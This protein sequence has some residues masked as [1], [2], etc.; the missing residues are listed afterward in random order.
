MISKELRDIVK[1]RKGKIVIFI[2]FFIPMIELVL[3]IL[4]VY[5]DYWLH[6]EA[7]GGTLDKH[8]IYHPSKAAFLSGTSL[9]H[10][11]QMLLVWLLPLF[12]LLL[13]DDSYIR[14]CRIGYNNI[15][16]VRTSKKSVFFSKIITGFIAGFTIIFFSMALNYLLSNLCFMGGT[17]F[18]GLETAVNPSDGILYISLQHPVITYLIYIFAFSFIAGVYSVFCVSLS[19]VI[20]SYK[21]LY[22]ACVVI[23]FLQILSPFSI[24]YAI[25]PFIEYGLDKIIPAILIL[26]ALV[27]LSVI[28]GLYAKVKYERI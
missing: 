11:P 24:T 14:E 15:I 3:N 21:M 27:L 19:F 22:G 7:Y 12:L 16:S 1:S 9:G 18:R 10:M 2:I 17:S 20:G 26:L 13:Y 5:A 6:P 8:I 25:Q 23:W 4:S 28:V